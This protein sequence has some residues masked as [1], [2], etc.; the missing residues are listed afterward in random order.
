MTKKESITSNTIALVR[1]R[2]LLAQKLLEESDK[3]PNAEGYVIT[4]CDDGVFH[5]RHEREA[6]VVY[7]L[8]TCFDLL[9]QNEKF[10]TFPDWLN[11]KKNNHVNE[12]KEAL[13]QLNDSKNVSHVDAAKKLH[14]HYISLYGV[15]N[16]FENGINKLSDYEKEKLLSTVDV[17][18]L[19]KEALDPANKNTSFP[20][21]KIVDSHKEYR[22]KIKY[23]FGMRNAFTHKLKQRNFLSIPSMSEFGLNNFPDQIPPEEKA[24]WTIFISGGKVTYGGA[25]Q[26]R[27]DGKYSFTLQ[28]WPFVLF[29]VLNSAIGDSFDRTQIK[30]RFSVLIFLDG[31]SRYEFIRSIDHESL[32]EKIKI[33][34]GDNVVAVKN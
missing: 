2:L 21:I 24:S 6:L 4:N 5:P 8:L 16:S 34:L 27:V 25:H 23:L 18:L 19:P 28:D 13:D 26:E 33:Y 3:L 14:E 17:S 11:S 22:L 31:E 29:D 20:G 1:A 15:R 7:L 10:L 32:H 30:L 12:R 9:G